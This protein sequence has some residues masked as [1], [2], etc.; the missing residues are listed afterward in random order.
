MR[1]AVSTNSNPF[2]PVDAAILQLLPVVADNNSWL[3]PFW[4]LFS[5]K[6]EPSLLAVK[7]VGR[8]TVN[9][10]HNPL[11][12]KTNGAQFLFQ[13]FSVELEQY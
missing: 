9:D 7:E 2:S 12:Q 1:D 5:S 11:P 6:E 8:R 10:W 4:N 3:S 13:S